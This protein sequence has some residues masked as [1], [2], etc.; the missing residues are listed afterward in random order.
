MLHE[1]VVTS[2]DLSLPLALGPSSLYKEGEGEGDVH[3]ID[4][5]CY[6]LFICFFF[7]ALICEE[8]YLEVP[9]EQPVT[10]VAV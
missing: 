7:L 3:L 2:L 5:S 8:S 4:C 10:N 9:V 6:G 1:P